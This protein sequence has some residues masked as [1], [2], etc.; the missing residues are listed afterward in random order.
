MTQSE[1]AHHKLVSPRYRNKYM[2]YDRI[3]VNIILK[4]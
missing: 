3:I 4:R 1:K 2:V